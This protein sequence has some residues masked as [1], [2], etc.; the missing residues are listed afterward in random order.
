YNDAIRD[1][2][3]YIENVNDKAAAYSARGLAYYQIKQYGD[4]VADLEMAIR[5]NPSLEKDF[6][7]V[8]TEA[9][10]NAGTK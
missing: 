9:K 6:S 1:L 7:A 4:A 5:L 2:T 10:N 8:L 3:T